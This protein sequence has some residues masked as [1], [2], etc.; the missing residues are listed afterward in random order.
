MT[1]PKVPTAVQM[2][3]AT[4]S[5]SVFIAKVRNEIPPITATTVMNVGN[6]RVKPSLGDYLTQWRICVAKGMLRGGNP[7]KQIAQRVGYAD[8]RSFA[9]AFAQACG[10]SPTE[11]LASD[12]QERKAPS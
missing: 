7:I 2:G 12:R 11:W 10:Q 9:R 8:A 5:G 1:V 6:G 4:L 3:W